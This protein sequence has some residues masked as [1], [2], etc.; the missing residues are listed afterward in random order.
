MPYEIE[1][2]DEEWKR[3]L[4]PDAYRVL[5]HAGTEPAFAN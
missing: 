1:H 4:S 5:R 3:M 2:T